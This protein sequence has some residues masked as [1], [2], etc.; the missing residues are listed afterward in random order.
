MLREKVAIVTGG[1]SGIGAAI[2][3][4]FAE[5]G[6]AVV[7]ADRDEERA[8]EIARQIGGRGGRVIAQR[9]DVARAQEV[10]G[11]V[12]GA[13]ERLGRLDI[14]VACAGI[15]IQKA[16]LETSLEEWEAIM[17]VNLTGVFLCG[18]AA[19]RAMARNGTGRIINISSGAGL[20][21]I[22]GRSAYGA[23]KGGVIALTKVMA[24]ELGPHGITVNAIA[25]GPIE[26]PLTRRMHTPETRAAYVG[27]S[28]LHRYGTLDELAAA[29]A[30]LASDGAG[31]ITGHTLVVDGGMTSSG[32]LFK[33]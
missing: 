11:M 1:G 30:F 7:V 9:V 15:G 27:A 24:A 16:F 3:T 26:T 29:A 2:A 18:Q 8:Q 33:V 17:A 14:V 25:P 20:R 31:Y 10:D 32:P 12:A 23:S 13:V 6:A 4:R 5:E 21:G 28:P 19:A 22:P